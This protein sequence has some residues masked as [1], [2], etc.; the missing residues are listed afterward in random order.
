[1]ASLG[2]RPEH[3]E[4]ARRARQDAR[5][6]ADAASGE[7]RRLGQEA[8]AAREAVAGVRG[9]L[10]GAR[11]LQNK[12]SELAEDARHLARTAELM[13]A[14]RN[15]V[16]A[17]IGPRLSAQ[18][19]DLF[20]E[21]TDHEY[22][23]L[24]VDP[25]SYELQIRDHGVVYGMDRFSG[26]E[27]DLANLALRVAISEQVRFQSGGA[28]GLLVLDEVFGPLDE[29]RRERMLCALDRLRA[30]FRQ[31]L[32]VTHD[33]HIKEQLTSAVGVEKLQGRR[34]RARLL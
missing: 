10:D 16:V 22:D 23:R 20:A 29:D 7:E 33:S 5:A 15:S 32:V 17:S 3:L 19:A 11:A 4:A 28:V 6:A 8:A 31:V 12:V 24:E 2:F 34:A 21:L 25:D 18:A 14:F 30:R 13:G 9:R 27:T 26:S 1:M